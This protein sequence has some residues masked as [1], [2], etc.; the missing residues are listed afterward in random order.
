M[1]TNAKFST[2]YLQIK[3]STLKGSYTL[4]KWDSF[5]GW[6]NMIHHIN[7]MKGKNYMILSGW[8]SHLIRYII[9]L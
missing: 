4:I 1:N 3:Y 6:F 5:Q 2:K 8:T 7:I 9:H